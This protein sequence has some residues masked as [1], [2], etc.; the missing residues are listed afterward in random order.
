M[1]FRMFF[2]VRAASDR[3]SFY[4][5]LWRRGRIVTA[6]DPYQTGHWTNPNIHDTHSHSTPHN[7]WF[8]EDLPDITMRHLLYARMQQIA[9]GLHL[10]MESN[11]YPYP[12]SKY[13]F[14]VFGLDLLADQHGNV[15]LIEANDKSGLYSIAE[16]PTYTDNEVSRSFYV[17]HRYTFQDFTQDYFDWI[18]THGIHPFY[19]GP[20]PIL[21]TFSL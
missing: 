1:H 8:P 9:V 19:G 5:E 20:T 16:P 17:N 15:I 12:E 21:K 3:A 18:Y 13:A 10:I 2:L 6:T 7:L 14:H 4:T 11:A